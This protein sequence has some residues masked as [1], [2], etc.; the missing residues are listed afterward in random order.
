MVRQPVRS[1][2]P[3]RLP[4][5]VLMVL[6]LVPFACRSLGPEEL[7]NRETAEEIWRH[8]E[9]VVALAIEGKQEGDQFIE[10]VLFFAELTGV[11]I[12]VNMSTMGFIPKTETIRDLERVREWYAE[13]RECLYYDAV[14]ESVR[15]R[16]PC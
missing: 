11:E 3:R 14:R 9:E 10:A 12:E 16:N 4:T 8:H 1:R 6:L 7:E 15:L 2:S 13:H 5:S